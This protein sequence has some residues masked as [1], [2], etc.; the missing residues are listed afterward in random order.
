VIEARVHVRGGPLDGAEALPL[1]ALP[2][3]PDSVL[4]YAQHVPHDLWDDGEG[5]PVDDEGALIVHRYQLGARPC[6]CGALVF[7]YLGCQ[8]AT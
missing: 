3:P 8:P 2:R 4:S 7:T 1:R 6:R 5:H